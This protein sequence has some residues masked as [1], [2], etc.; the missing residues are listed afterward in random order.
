MLILDLTCP[1]S[2]HEGILRG[3]I[4]GTVGRRWRTLL[5]ISIV[6]SLVTILRRTTT[7]LCL[8][9]CFL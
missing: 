5:D 3:V 1:S 2:L 9:I 4:Q 7:D 6:T 8:L